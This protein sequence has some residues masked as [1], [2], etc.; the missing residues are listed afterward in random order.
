M[1]FRLL[2]RSFLNWS[3]ERGVSRQEQF[4]QPSWEKLLA[5]STWW[6]HSDLIR[7]RKRRR[8][9]HSNTSLVLSYPKKRRRENR[10]TF[11]LNQNHW[12]KT[13]QLSDGRS[14]SK[15][16]LKRKVYI[17]HGCCFSVSPPP[18][19]ARMER[20]IEGR[21]AEIGKVRRR[22]RPLGSSQEEYRRLYHRDGAHTHTHTHTYTQQKKGKEE[23]EEG[24]DIFFREGEDRWMRRRR[25][26][27]TGGQRKGA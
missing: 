17:C 10:S 7:K 5:S 4:N 19:A 20:C 27:R 8:N 9:K 26:R 11:E 21:G 15:G 1:V 2:L 14:S 3:L 12:R 22:F 16:N 24:A 23:E 13:S 25:G 18:I 6:V